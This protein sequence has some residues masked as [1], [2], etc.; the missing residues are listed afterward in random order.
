MKFFAVLSL[1]ALG[2]S[3]VVIPE[4]SSPVEES[5]LEKRQDCRSIHPACAGGNIIQRGFP[6]QCPGQAS[7]CDL[8]ACPRGRRS[9]CG[10]RG[11]GCVFV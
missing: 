5:E 6:C 4:N 7:P 3:A 2:A 11:T 10:S 9:V 8:W 1:L